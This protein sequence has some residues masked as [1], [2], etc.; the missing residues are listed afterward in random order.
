MTECIGELD[1]GVLIVGYGEYKKV[2]YW[3]IKNSWG[4]DWGENGYV[5]IVKN[6]GACGLNKMVTWHCENKTL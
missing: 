6:K 3:K 1:H 2:K 5:R 4:T